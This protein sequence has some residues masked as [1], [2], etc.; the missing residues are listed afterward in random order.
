MKLSGIKQIHQ[1]IDRAQG[2]M[3]HLE[4]IAGLPEKLITRIAGRGIAP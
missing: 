4:A 2:G 3:P 1:A